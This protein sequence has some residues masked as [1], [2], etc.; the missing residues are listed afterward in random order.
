MRFPGKW[1]SKGSSPASIQQERILTT[2]RLRDRGTSAKPQP[3]RGIIV[4]PAP[5]G[6][7]L[8][9]QLPAVYS[10]IQGWRVYK[11][12][13]QTLYQNLADRG[14][15]K[16]FVECTAATISPITNF[17]VSSLNGLGVESLKVQT[18]GA[19][20]N[21]VGAPAMPGVPPGYNTG[22][23]GGGDTGTRHGRQLV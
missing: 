3:P 19:A 22:S 2:D 21:E 6:V 11:T 9:W 18:Q 5:R 15:R 7:F 13:E 23:G 16:L 12:D 17:F 14:V 10:D 20:L 8:T 1:P 4:Q